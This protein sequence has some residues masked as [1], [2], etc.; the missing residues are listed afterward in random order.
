MESSGYPNGVSS[1]PVEELTYEQAFSELEAIVTAL[2]SDQNTLEDCLEL[3]ER[4]Q[5]LARFCA[6]LLESAEL[7]VQQLSGEDLVDF[8]SQL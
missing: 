6:N 7:K 1:T 8:V 4:G 3:F 2:E 5:S